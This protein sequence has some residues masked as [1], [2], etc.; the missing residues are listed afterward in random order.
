L[1]RLKNKDIEDVKKKFLKRGEDLP[2]P[3]KKFFEDTE[4]LSLYLELM[5]E[6]FR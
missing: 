2:S 6:P 3:D 4:K 5:S 1:N